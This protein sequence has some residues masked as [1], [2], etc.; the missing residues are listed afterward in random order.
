MNPERVERAIQFLLD[1]QATHDG[2]LAR[3]ENTVHELSSTVQRLEHTVEKM[4]DDLYA[5]LHQ[6]NEGL[7]ALTGVA[8]KTMLMVQQVA[9][10]Q[11][12]TN[13]RLEAVE[14]RVDNSEN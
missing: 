11:I 4:S 5:G 7:Q 3:L 12:S 2:R 6:M 9:Q 14:W 13:R 10:S 8:E 1:N